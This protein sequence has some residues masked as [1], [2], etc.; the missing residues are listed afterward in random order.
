MRRTNKTPRQGVCTTYVGRR[1]LP[2]LPKERRHKVPP[3]S[4]LR[5]PG[6]ISRLGEP[7][8]SR[9]E[10]SQKR[11]TRKNDRRETSLSR[12]WSVSLFSRSTFILLVVH[13]DKC[14][15]VTQ[16]QLLQ[17]LSKDSVLS[18][19]LFLQGSYICSQYLLV[20]RP[21]NIL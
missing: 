20:W 12:N 18:I 6:K 15:R 13:R 8:R 17:P 1:H 19:S 10:F 2:G 14:K 3:C 11:R 4:D 5:S 21:M 9:W 16:G 7:P